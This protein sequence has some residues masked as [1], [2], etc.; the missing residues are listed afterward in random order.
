MRH[1]YCEV[2][3]F[4]TTAFSGNPLAVIA[5]AD[6]L[7]DQQM[8][9]IANWTNLSETAFLLRP[10]TPEVDYRVR[11]FTP[12][13]ELPFAGHPTLGSA[14]AWL[15]FGGTPRQPGRLTQECAAGLIPI[16]QEAAG[17]GPLFFA[18]P[19][20]QKKGP[21]S[22]EELADSC[23][24]IGVDPAAVISHAWVDNGPG[25]RM[26]QLADAAAVRAIDTFRPT[27]PH[28]LGVVGMTG[29]ASENVDHSDDDKDDSPAYVIRAFTPDHEDPVTGSLNGGAAQFLRSQGA[30][31]PEYWVSQGTC[32]GRAG[33]VEIRDTGEDLWV[34]GRATV[35]IA[36]HVDI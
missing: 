28:K 18:T 32:R 1:E 4:A 19:P 31:G 17:D 27:T 14:R 15:A 29:Q 26:V 20:L 7:S 34:G 25:W 33:R 16:R 22:E 30:V 23:R 12:H 5:D 35:R 9:A 2:D 3:V 8:Q 24:A 21:L 10:T 13:T 11:I 36:G 6:A